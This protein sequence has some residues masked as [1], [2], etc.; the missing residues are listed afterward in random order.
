[1]AN[2]N[3]QRALE[4]LSNDPSFANDSERS[5]YFDR[6]SQAAL[7]V[8]V[9][10]LALNIVGIGFF[11]PDW[12]GPVAATLSIVMAFALRW[13]TKGRLTLGF[14]TGESPWPSIVVLLFM[15]SCALAMRVVFEAKHVL[16]MTQLVVWALAVTVLFVLAYAVSLTRPERSIG[17]VLRAA[18]VGVPLFFVVLKEANIDFDNAPPARYSAVLLGKHIET[19]K[20]KTPVFTIGPWGPVKAADTDRVQFPVYEHTAVGDRVCVVL[21]AGAL[22][23]P[24]YTI[25]RCA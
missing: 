21:H 12:V 3:K 20:H 14:S 10:A 9:A 11:V 4:E 15:P 7:G 25:E 2:D 18:V 17:N 5:A 23:I 16:S 6:L 24:W 22:G 13:C 8:S 1:L 19:G